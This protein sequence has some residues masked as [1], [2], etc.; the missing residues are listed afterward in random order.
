MTKRALRLW[1]GIPLL[2]FASYELL[3]AGCDKF[4][5]NV[6]IEFYGRVVEDRKTGHH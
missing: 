5:G 3:G 1:I 6:P 2:M 4:W